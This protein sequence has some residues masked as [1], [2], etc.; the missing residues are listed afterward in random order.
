MKKP[1]WGHVSEKHCEVW[2]RTAVLCLGIRELVWGSVWPCRDEP[3]QSTTSVNLIKHNICFKVFLCVSLSC[4]SVRIRWT[5]GASWGLWLTFVLWRITRKTK[6][7]L[8]ASRSTAGPT[9]S[10]VSP[11]QTP[12]ILLSSFCL[13]PQKYWAAQLLSTL[14]R[15]RNVSWAAK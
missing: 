5:L 4:F 13:C 11:A 2:S 14:I 9:N 12:L 3:Y 6:T 7:R 8:L 15:R 10:S 1:P